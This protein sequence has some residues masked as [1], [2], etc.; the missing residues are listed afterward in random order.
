[1]E[2]HPTFAV[3]IALA[4]SNASMDIVPFY[5]NPLRQSA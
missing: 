4:I 3:N 5:A 1:M 2:H